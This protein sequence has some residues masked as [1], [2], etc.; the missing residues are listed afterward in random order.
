[1]VSSIR[2]GPAAPEAMASEKT[3][4]EEL[5][6]RHRSPEVARDQG[7]GLRHQ[8]AGGGVSLP[9]RASS[10]PIERGHPAFG[11]A[12]ILSSGARAS[13]LPERGHRVFRS[14]G[15][16]SSGAR[17]SCP[18]WDRGRPVRSAGILPA[19]DVVRYA[20]IWGERRARCPA[21]GQDARE[22][23]A[24]GTSALP[25]AVAAFSTPST[26]SESKRFRLGGW[27]GSQGAVVVISSITYL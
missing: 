27:M 20:A 12:D 26:A 4:P 17:T 15:I 7:A 19:V 5:P 3:S 18:H 8:S 21:G 23:S 2:Q 22:P 13:C 25:K 9:D 11:S 6:E 16:G 10:S 14:A 1:M 24:D